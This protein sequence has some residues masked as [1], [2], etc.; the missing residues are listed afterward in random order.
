MSRTA[1]LR[2]LVQ[3]APTISPS[4]LKVDYGNMH[5]EVQLLE[6]GGASL[7]HLDVMDGILCLICPTEPQ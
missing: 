1:N 7:L 6:S 3:Q 2:N 4:I 5:R